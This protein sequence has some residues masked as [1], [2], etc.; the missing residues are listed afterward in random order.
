MGSLSSV[1]LGGEIVT[2]TAQVSQP[3]ADVL[4]IKTYKRFKHVAW[5]TAAL[6]S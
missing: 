2:P 4:E 6:I 5:L 1:N 3:Q